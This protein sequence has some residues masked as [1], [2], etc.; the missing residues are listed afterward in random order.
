MS[1]R[2]A[3]LHAGA[4]GVGKMD[5]HGFSNALGSSRSVHSERHRDGIRNGMAYRAIPIAE[6]GDRPSW[7]TGSELASCDG[8]RLLRRSNHSTEEAPW[9]SYRL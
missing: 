1:V 2:V 4:A 5:V 7:D 8:G 9:N 3:A 6:G